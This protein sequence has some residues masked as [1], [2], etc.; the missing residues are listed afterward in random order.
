MNN[1]ASS[2]CIYNPH[3]QGIPALPQPSGHRIIMNNQSVASVPQ[4]TPTD[5]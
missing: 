5:I 2:E 4:R 1:Y 3:M